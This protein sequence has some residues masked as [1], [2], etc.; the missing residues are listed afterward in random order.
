MFSTIQKQAVALYLKSLKNQRDILT[1]VLCTINEA[2][3][4]CNS[5][6]TLRDG[7]HRSFIEMM[8]Q[9]ELINKDNLCKYSTILTENDFT[10]EEQKE[11][12]GSSTT[13]IEDTSTNKIL[14]SVSV[15]DDASELPGSLQRKCLELEES[16]SSL[17]DR[18]TN[19]EVKLSSQNK[20]SKQCRRDLKEM[21]ENIQMLNEKMMRQSDWTTTL[22]ENIEQNMNLFNEVKDS[23]NGTLKQMKHSINEMKDTT[24]HSNKQIEE[25]WEQVKNTSITSNE[26]DTSV[27]D[28]SEKQLKLE[29]NLETLDHKY[30]NVDLKCGTL[31][32]LLAKKFKIL[33]TVKEVMGTLSLSRDEIFNQLQENA[34]AA[35]NSPTPVALCVTLQNNLPVCAG[36]IITQFEDP[37]SNSGKHFN[38]KEGKFKVPTSGLYVICLTISLKKKNVGSVRVHVC[39]QSPRKSSAT[40]SK[41]EEGDEYCTVVIVNCFHSTATDVTV[42]ELDA[43]DELYLKVVKVK[44]CV[45]L[46]HFSS[47][48]IFKL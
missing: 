31:C 32:Q 29:F 26:T 47:L 23:V 19:L 18:L 30:M 1:P 39:C 2:I 40:E 8:Q 17:N 34:L 44:T 43:G 46:S 38:T 35:K 25:L 27:K 41:M 20:K 3:E 33:E 10:Q 7:N 13:G 42:I 16:V 9:L 21:E 37:V 24:T 5:C 12:S 48:T 4:E 22:S 11:T 15:N 36:D 28:L 45:R 14:C 6:L